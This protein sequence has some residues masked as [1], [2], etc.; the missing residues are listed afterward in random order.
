VV[1]GHGARTH[2]HLDEVTG[3]LDLPSWRRKVTTAAV[4]LGAGAAAVVGWVGAAKAQVVPCPDPTM[5]VEH[6]ASPVVTL[7][8]TGDGFPTRSADSIGGLRYALSR[9]AFASDGWPQWAAGSFWSP[10]LERVDGHYLLYFSAIRKGDHRHCIGVAISNTPDGGFHDVGQP[11]VSDETAG[12]ID[13]TLLRAHGALYLLFK[14][15][16]NANL[17]PA[18]IYGRPL[19]HSGLAAGR[20]KLLLSSRSRGWEE[21]VVEAPTAVHL[22]NTTYLLY[23]GGIYTAAGYAEGE[24]IRR[25]RPLGRYQ[26]IGNRPV[27]HGGRYWVGTGG[28]SIVRD[29]GRLLLAYNAFPARGQQHR[30]RLYVRPLRLVGGV[31]R[32]TGRATRIPL[33]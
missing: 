28:G 26:R 8:C 9:S 1:L 11:L 20:R 33:F 14:I 4:G 18:I 30:R 10:D 21:G 6:D 5:L 27:L 3:R 22:R 16:G 19:D 25:G 23:S 31:L 7:M 2:K 29:R 12:A 24:A 15:D 17:N 32:P 13:P